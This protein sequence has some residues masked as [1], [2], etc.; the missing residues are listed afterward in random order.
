MKKERII[1]VLKKHTRSNPIMKGNVE[2]ICDFQFESIASDLQ[3]SG[4]RK[5]AERQEIIEAYKKKYGAT[6]HPNPLTDSELRM[7]DFCIELFGQSVPE[8][9]DE[10]IELRAKELF[11]I[12]MELVDESPISYSHESLCLHE[13][14]GLRA[15]A[16]W[17]K[18]ELAKRM[19]NEVTMHDLR[20]D[21]LARDER[22]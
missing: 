6:I 11:N 21:D 14:Q 22:C 15:G 13:C 18:S 4:E 7:L 12:H 9:S 19:N 17:Y 5:T 2:I 10:E 20:V 8:I 3:E 1:E 16:K